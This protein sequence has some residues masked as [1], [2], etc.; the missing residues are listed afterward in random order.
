MQMEL[1][2][3]MKCPKGA[4]KVYLNSAFLVSFTDVLLGAFSSVLKRVLFSKLDV[5]ESQSKENSYYFRISD[6]VA[7][8]KLEISKT[9]DEN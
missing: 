6:K 2:I 5:T 7:E 1:L 9:S 3:A 4:V 8:S